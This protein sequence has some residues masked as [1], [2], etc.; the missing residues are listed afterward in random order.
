MAN[1][2]ITPKK[3][4][5]LSD[6]ARGTLRRCAGGYRLDASSAV[7]TKRVLHQLATEG[8]VQIDLFEREVTITSQGL[9]AAAALS[10]RAA[11]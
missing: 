11:A 1:S 2:P 10:T 8:L 6:C 4:A 5:A 9:E 3:R 7:H